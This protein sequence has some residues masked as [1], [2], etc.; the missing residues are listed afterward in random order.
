M[1][2]KPQKTTFDAP[3]PKPRRGRGRSQAGMTFIETII[4]IFILFIVASGLLTMGVVATVTTE[5]QGHLLARVT[6]Y[7][8]DKMEQLISLAYGD[9]DLPTPGIGTDTTVFPT[10]NPLTPPPCTTGT[11]LH[12]GGS[13]DPSAPVDKYVDYLDV[14]GNLLGGGTPPPA[15]WYYIRVWEISSPSANLKQITVTCAV[16]FAV[17]SRGLPVRSTVTTLKANPF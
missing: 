14:N 3:P 2:G 5:N 11:G 16:R 7:A 13:S 10:C 15:G 12:L 4:A 8:Q 6:E 17:G 9:G 1:E